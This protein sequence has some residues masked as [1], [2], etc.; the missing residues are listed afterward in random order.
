MSIRRPDADVVHLE[1][2]VQSPQCGAKLA[3]AQP[4]LLRRSATRTPCGQRAVPA[5]VSTSKASL[6]KNPSCGG[7][8]SCTFTLARAPAWSRCTSTSAVPYDASPYTSIGSDPAGVFGEGAASSVVGV[9]GEGAA[10]SV[11][12]VFGEGA[13]SSVVGASGEGAAPTVA[14]VAGA[15]TEPFSPRAASSLGSW[16]R[17]ITSASSSFATLPSPTLAAVTFAPV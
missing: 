3:L 13:A 12:G 7:E 15:S 11:V 16:G 4:S 9:F 17:G 1:R 5:V 10:S 14:G 6:L 8:A 2:S